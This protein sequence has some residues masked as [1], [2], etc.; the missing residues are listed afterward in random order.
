MTRNPKRNA[1]VIAFPFVN[2]TILRTR[3][4][5]R[6]AK[7]GFG[8]IIIVVEA[9]SAIVRKIVT[10]EVSFAEDLSIGW[11]GKALVL[12]SG[13]DFGI[14]NAFLKHDSKNIYKVKSRFDEQIQEFLICCIV[15]QFYASR[16]LLMT[17]NI[18]KSI[19]QY[20]HVV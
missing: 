4:R 17:N 13:A 9:F 7:S 19:F 14:V 5:I 1:L 2:R 6:S 3:I 10:F 15:S 11:T 16:I 20:I 12:G 8:T 18:V